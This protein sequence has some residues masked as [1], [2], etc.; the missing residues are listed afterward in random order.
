MKIV[1]K[2]RS[3]LYLLHKANII[4]TIIVNFKTLP[5]AQAIH[6]PIIIYGSMKLDSI[7]GSIEIKAPIKTNMIRI[8][9]KYEMEVTSHKTAQLTIDGKIIFRG[10]AQF[11]L[12]VII[13]VKKDAILDFGEMSGIA[14]RG[15]ICCCK[16]ITIGKYVRF[17]S[18]LLLMDSSFHSMI[19]TETGLLDKIEE[20]ISIGNFTYGGSNVTILK[21]TKTPN[22]FTI[23]T[24]A[25]CNKDYTSLGE[26]TMIGG[27]PAKL[28]KRNI[29]RAFEL[30]YKLKL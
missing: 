21:G 4:K 18:G 11:G 7:T 10:Q 20:E 29:R 15:E 9:D 16:Q 25:L 3:I 5:Y 8:G 22:Y 14:S 30:E 12:D 23:C 24:S 17:G 27:V 13:I 2:L 26:N 28:V 6:M 19:N 1:T